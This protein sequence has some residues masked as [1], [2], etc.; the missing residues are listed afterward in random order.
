MKDGG[1]PFNELLREPT[2]SK[3]LIESHQLGGTRTH[4]SQDMYGIFQMKFLSWVC[5][6][7]EHLSQKKRDFVLK[8]SKQL[9][10]VSTKTLKE[11]YSKPFCF[12]MDTSMLGVGVGFDTKGWRNS[13]KGSG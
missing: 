3:E 13:C 12:L 7:V 5:E 11:D 2:L 9:C 4:K 6:E 10:F 8:N 1:K